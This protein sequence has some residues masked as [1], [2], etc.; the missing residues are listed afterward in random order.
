MTHNYVLV[1]S[2]NGISLYHRDDDKYVVVEEYGN[3]VYSIMPGDLP[4]ETRPG[5]WYARATSAGLDYVA[6]GYSK[7]YAYR[8]FREFCNGAKTN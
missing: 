4:S 8:K 1:K 2:K 6:N 3:Q 7:S 5:R